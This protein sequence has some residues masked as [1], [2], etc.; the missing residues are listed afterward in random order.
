MIPGMKSSL[1]EERLKT[2][3]LFSLEFRRMRGDLIETYRILRGLDGVAMERMFPRVG[4]TRS[5]GHKLRLKGRSFKIEMRRNF[6]SQ[7]MVN[8]WNSLPQKTVEARSFTVFNTKIDR[9]LINKG[10]RGYAENTGEWN[11]KNIYVR[12]AG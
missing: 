11:E 4:K 5:R 6:S 3:G 9:F 10:I 8:V 12:M 1:Y 2:L 7:R